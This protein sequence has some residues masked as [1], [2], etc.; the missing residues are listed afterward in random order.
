MRIL[1][2][3]AALLLA[4]KAMQKA[5]RPQPMQKRLHDY[6]VLCGPRSPTEV[7]DRTNQYHVAKIFVH[8][9]NLK[10]PYSFVVAGNRSYVFPVSKLTSEAYYFPGDSLFMNSLAYREMIDSTGPFTL[11]A[12]ECTE[13]DVERFYEEL[14]AANPGEHIMLHTFPAEFRSRFTAKKTLP[15][16]VQNQELQEE[17]IQDPV[18][19]ETWQ[20]KEQISQAQNSVR[21]NEKQARAQ[22]ALIETLKKN[23]EQL[24]MDRAMYEQQHLE[25]VRAHKALQSR[26]STFE[27]RNSFPKEELK[28]KERDEKR[29]P[30]QQHQQRHFQDSF[31]SFT[32]PINQVQ[33]GS[34]NEETFSTLSQKRTPP[35]TYLHTNVQAPQQSFDTQGIF[36]EEKS[37][38]G[39]QQESAM[40][41]KFKRQQ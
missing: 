19:R 1:I 26:V 32:R 31:D 36:V 5:Q 16:A 7:T 22:S 40:N 27:P 35:A 15:P 2:S 4:A 18:H 12:C 38:H 13:E 37:P 39:S 10:K 8:E 23:C 28:S 34:R 20:L 21:L 3:L 41:F 11:Y 25:C 14:A 30:T 24:E 17:P 29:K 6:A 33:Y 9:V